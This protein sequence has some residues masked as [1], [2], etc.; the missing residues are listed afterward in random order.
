M[1]STLKLLL[2]LII[3]A[4][5]FINKQDERV[6]NKDSAH[7]TEAAALDNQV[8]HFKER[9]KLGVEKQSLSR[10]ELSVGEQRDL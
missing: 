7:I 9:I 1:R 5:L 3:L 4:P 8:N 10:L 2:N 6:L